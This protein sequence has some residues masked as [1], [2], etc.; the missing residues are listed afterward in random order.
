MLL[1]PTPPLTADGW[2][3]AVPDGPIPSPDKI[4]GPNAS[5][6]VEVPL[7]S[8]TS[9]PVAGRETSIPLLMVNAFPPGRSVWPLS[10]RVVG[11]G[12]RLFG[13]MDRICEPTVTPVGIEPIATALP[14]TMRAEPVEGSEMGVLSIVTTPPGVSFSPSSVRACGV[15][16][17]AV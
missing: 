12:P 16:S 2:P 14:L 13:V 8:T 17:R 3:P 5:L 7:I 10:I 4:A 9:V 1:L 11:I 6:A 15:E